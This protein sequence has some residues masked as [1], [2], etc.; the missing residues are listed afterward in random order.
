MICV[1]LALGLQRQQPEKASTLNEV[2]LTKQPLS[3]FGLKIIENRS[4]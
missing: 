1:F 2:F 3:S 4:N